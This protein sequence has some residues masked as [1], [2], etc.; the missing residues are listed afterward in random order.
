MATTT[1]N[2]KK[3]NH[4]EWFLRLPRT[5]HHV[6]G[7]LVRPLLT[8]F[9]D[10]Y[11]LYPFGQCR[12]QQMWF[13]LELG[14][15]PSRH[16]YSQEQLL[17]TSTTL[18]ALLLLFL[19]LLWVT[20]REI[21]SNRSLA[22]QNGWRSLDSI[23]LSWSYSWSTARPNPLHQSIVIHDDHHANRRVLRIEC[24]ATSRSPCNFQG[25]E[26]G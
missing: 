19:L 21:E 16:H 9:L 4:E 6:H 8:T 5:T 22:G 3:R 26:T 15:P 11:I 18:A 12:Q 7:S 23:P 13:K 20:E 17:S 1:L 14:T 2:N 24:N 10:M 25:F